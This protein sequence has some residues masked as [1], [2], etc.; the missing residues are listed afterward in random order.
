[1]D[2]AFEQPKLD[3]AMLAAFAGAALALAGIGLYS[4]FMLF[5]SD[6]TREIAVRLAIGASPAGMI[7]L[8]AGAAGRLLTG[9][10]VLGI[11]LTAAA[12]RML[13]GVLFG[14]SSFDAGTLAASA[15]VIAAVAMAAVTAPAIRAAR[16]APTEALRGD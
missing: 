13:R 14:V 9:G 11:A 1:V 7:R 15:A 2:G 12:D 8:I 5:V 6:R 16:I 4:L 3:A 10:I